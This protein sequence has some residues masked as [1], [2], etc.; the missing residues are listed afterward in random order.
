MP[1]STGKGAQR[2]SLHPPFAR[3]D[4]ERHMTW[5]QRVG[6]AAEQN[7]QSS[8]VTGVGGLAAGTLSMEA[9]PPIERFFDDL[10]SIDDFLLSAESYPV[11]GAESPLMHGSEAHGDAP[12]RP[13]ETDAEGWAAADWQSYDWS[14]ISS[15]GAPAPEAVEA[16]AAWT[17]TNWDSAAP[18]LPEIADRGEQAASEELAEALDEIAR[19]IRSGELSLERF[20]GTPPE[21]AIAA[22]FAALLR[23]RG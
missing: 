1:D 8:M 21:A 22:A 11:K 6:A 10:P 15:L 19:K 20:R 13:L 18:G 4:Q 5:Q 16:H 23:K 7:E 12:F 17:S 3:P 2:Q 9:L 14:E